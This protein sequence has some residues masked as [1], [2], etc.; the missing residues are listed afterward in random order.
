M[1]KI[2]ILILCVSFALAANAQ[3]RLY[4]NLQTQVVDTLK[5]AETVYFASTVKIAKGVILTMQVL[6]AEIGG[7]SD[8]T[9]FVQGSVDG[10]TWERIT[11]K[12]DNSI[13]FNAT[14]SA[15]VA[16]Q[17]SEFTTVPDA[18]GLSVTF[19]SAPYPYFRWGATGTSNDTVSLAPF[20]MIREK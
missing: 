16:R 6:S 10:T 14:D 13:Y 18:Q 17:G 15:D 4:N 11:W 12:S 1:K 8:F 7:T 5:G 9:A 2:F 20:Y 19:T 3:K